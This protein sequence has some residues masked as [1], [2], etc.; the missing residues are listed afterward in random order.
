MQQNKRTCAALYLEDEYK[1]LV[2]ETH[3]DYK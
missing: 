3:F 1:Q 2:E